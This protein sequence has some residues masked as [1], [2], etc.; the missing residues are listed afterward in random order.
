MTDERIERVRGGLRFHVCPNPCYDHEDASAALDSLER[1]LTRL[2]AEDSDTYAD[3][4][5]HEQEE[6][7]RTK[8]ELTELREELGLSRAAARGAYKACEALRAERDAAREVVEALRT[9]VAD[10]LDGCG[11]YKCEAL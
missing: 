4:W 11:C 6:H 8:R 7:E 9:D 5:A 2:K 1:E 10:H 3:K